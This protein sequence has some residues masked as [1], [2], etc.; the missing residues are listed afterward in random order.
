[1]SNYLNF[2]GQHGQMSLEKMYK[3]LILVSRKSRQRRSKGSTC[4]KVGAIIA[5]HS[6]GH[7]DLFEIIG[8]AA[9]GVSADGRSCTHAEEDIIRKC[10]EEGVD[11]RGA[12]LFTTLEPCTTRS[13]FRT[14][15]AALIDAVGIKTVW[16][17][18]LDVDP[19]IYGRA[20][21]RFSRRRIKVEYIPLKHRERLRRWNAP[22]FERKVKEFDWRLF[23]RSLPAVIAH[24]LDE[25]R[26]LGLAHALFRLFDHGR[27]IWFR[28]QL[29]SFNDRDRFQA[30]WS[31][32]VL[33]NPNLAVRIVSDEKTFTAAV[34]GAIKEGMVQDVIGAFRPRDNIQLALLNRPR[35]GFSGVLF[36]RPHSKL[37][38][39]ASAA[40]LGMKG[41]PIRAFVI[42][43]AKQLG[44]K[45][46]VIR[47]EVDQVVRA[48]REWYTLAEAISRKSKQ[49]SA[50]GNG[51]S[52]PF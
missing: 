15:C 31:Q 14:P 35:S 33:M 34:Q 17:G 41:G 49:L 21:V 46:G 28:P 40:P 10:S 5:R 19:E 48:R 47:K 36:E 23:D 39:V 51:H 30:F 45:A 29:P 20:A 16:Q 32:G 38:Y 11:L 4:P 24:D 7:E 2:G 9:H 3:R 25:D 50:S 22:F 43:T 8:E 26:Y 6:S 37:A 1:M 18:L 27:I 52:A 44:D 12:V 42:S 13:D